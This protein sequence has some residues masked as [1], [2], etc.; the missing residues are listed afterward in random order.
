MSE[1]QEQ[2]ADFRTDD[3]ALAAYL[4]SE[5]YA[6]SVE[7]HGRKGWWIFGEVDGLYGCVDDYHDGMVE[8]E[9]K[10]YTQ[11]T[12]HCRKVL[13]DALGISRRNGKS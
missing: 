3:L 5:G 6:F 7:T 1:A 13:Y 10:R 2:R 11:A 12:G 9:P 8:V 4:H